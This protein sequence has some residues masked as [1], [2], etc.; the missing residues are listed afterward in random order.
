MT[1]AQ[2]R[3]CTEPEEGSER[4]TRRR[5]A[6][7]T[8]QRTGGRSSGS[9][10]QGTHRREERGARSEV[11]HKGAKAERDEDAP[12]PK[13]APIARRTEQPSRPQQE[14][15][16]ATGRPRARRGQTQRRTRRTAAA[17]APGRCPPSRRSGPR[18]ARPCFPSNPPTSSHFRL[19]H[20]PSVSVGLRDARLTACLSGALA[21]RF[22]I[23]LCTNRDSPSPSS[24]RPLRVHCV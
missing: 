1:N 6:S 16:G 15:G 17:N 7:P 18:A 5:R 2:G 24:P 11:R 20:Q 13:A 4:Q 19:L 22:P 8:P 9:K 21:S 23:R 14:H 12:D 3:I 10:G